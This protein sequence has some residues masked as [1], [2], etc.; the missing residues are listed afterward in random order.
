MAF[1]YKRCIFITHIVFV[2]F[3]FWTE[4]TKE[5]WW[6]KLL[7]HENDIDVNKIDCSRPFDELS[8]ETQAHIQQIQYDEE[9]KMKGRR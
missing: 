8:E 3:S 6:K 2:A 5:I 4:K 1:T 7:H 9:Q